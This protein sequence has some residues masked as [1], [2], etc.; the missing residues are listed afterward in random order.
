MDV[1]IVHTKREF[2]APVQVIPGQ[3]GTAVHGSLE[4]LQ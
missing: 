3:F 2:S 1:R 4:P